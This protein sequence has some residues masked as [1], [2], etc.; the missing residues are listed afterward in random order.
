MPRKKKSPAYP[1]FLIIG[2]QKAGTTWL[3][4][5]LLKHPQIWMPKVKELHYFDEKTKYRSSISAKL[6]GNRFEDQRWRSQ[7]ELRM[8]NYRNYRNRNIFNDLLWDLRYFLKTPN[9]TWYASLFEQGWNKISGEVT[10][11]Y[12]TL[13][14][15][16]IA[17]IR[18]IMP[19]TKIIFMMRNPMERAW[20]Q[21]MMA[22]GRETTV[23]DLQ[24]PRLN[25]HFVNARSRAF[26]NYMRTLNNWRRFYPEEQIF[27]GFLEDINFHPNQLIRRLYEFL[28]ADSSIEYRVIERKIHTR[29][30]DLMQTRS[31]IRLARIYR[32]QIR[33]L[34][35]SF[36]GYASFW[37]YCARRLDEDPPRLKTI[38]YP[39]TE[40]FLWD[41]WVS[42]TGQ[43]PGSGEAEA[44]SGPLAS[45]RVKN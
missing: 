10:P 45:I 29:D 28:G 40:S 23:E 5:N 35:E 42:S 4:Y 18:E 13:G 43:N 31:A 21:A 15:E 34:D 30:V 8:R 38:P 33:R 3:Y 41:E 11:D 37:H 22:F 6:W 32:E 26:T 24:F 7:L 19:E 17:H 16:T 36:G 27:V 20:S 39:L 1:D 14:P 2:A 44:Q 12:S 9:D 25:R